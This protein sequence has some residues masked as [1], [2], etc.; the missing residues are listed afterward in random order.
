MSK[1]IKFA[2]Q[3][4]YILGINRVR[5]YYFNK[6]FNENLFFCKSEMQLESQQSRCNIPIKRK[7]GKT[8]PTQKE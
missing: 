8:G 1:I 7:I 4:L 5:I 2:L 6:K 3:T